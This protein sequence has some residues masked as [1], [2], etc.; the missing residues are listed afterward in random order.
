M[1]LLPFRFSSRGIGPVRTA[2]DAAGFGLRVLASIIEF[3]PAP[4]HRLPDKV[5]A[6]ALDAYRRLAEVVRTPDFNV[7]GRAIVVA[8]ASSGAG[9]TTTARNLAS[10]LAQNGR[11]AV[12]V[13]CNPRRVARRRPGDGTAS[14]GF[15]GLLSNQLLRPSSTL[16]DTTEPGVKLIPAGSTAGARETLLHSTR[17]PLV[18]GSL[19]E[20]TDYVILDAGSLAED[21]GLL[22]R[23]SDA[24][25]LLFRSGRTSRKEAAAAATQLIEANPEVYG[26]V[27]NRAPV[28]VA[29]VAESVESM[30]A[31]VDE[32]VAVMEEEP[33]EL[34][35]EE[36]LAEL[37][38][39]M[40]S[41]RAVGRPADEE[42]TESE[43]EVTS[44]AAGS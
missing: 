15:A 34:S 10:L 28:T 41:M 31:E 30:V 11:K 14:T 1:P 23:L 18:V 37:E 21:L 26:V 35:V 38:E 24:A 4:G 39:I 6:E 33:S 9:C 17:L 42:A 25:L 20:M 29:T 8:G 44:A 3:E 16:Q 22:T 36:L 2:E 5:Y 27:L 7:R 43:E 40:A 32:A 12:V 13:D 19:R